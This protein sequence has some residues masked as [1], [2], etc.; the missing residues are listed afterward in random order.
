M[1]V[2]YSDAS[3]EVS[4]PNPAKLGLVCFDRLLANP[5]GL[6]A[7]VENSELACLLFRLQQITACEMLHRFTFWLAILTL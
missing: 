6:A 2:I 4:D 5:W 1:R 7:V 3:Y